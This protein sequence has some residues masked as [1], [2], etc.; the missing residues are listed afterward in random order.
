M[1]PFFIILEINFCFLIYK[2]YNVAMKK[3]LYLLVLL[4]TLSACTSTVEM[5]HKSKNPFY[6]DA[7]KAVVIVGEIGDK[8]LGNLVVTMNTGKKLLSASEHTLS[9][10]SALAW[11][12][13]IGDSFTLA[14]AEIPRLG[15]SVEFRKAHTIN[16]EESG[17]Y[18]YGTI[19]TKS[20]LTKSNE[21]E[22]EEAVSEQVNAVLIKKSLPIIIQLAQKKYPYLFN[23]LKPI[24]FK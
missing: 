1:L 22:P 19:L 16:I 13:D 12:I 6:Y 5:L 10:I 15:S 9:R 21:V 4:L 7:N 14:R 2:I 11:Q 23:E 17:I 20:S 8:R 24:N 18:Y 3:C